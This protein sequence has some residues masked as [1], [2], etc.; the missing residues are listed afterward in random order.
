MLGGSA[1][2]RGM[3]SAALSAMS[4]PPAPRRRALVAAFVMLLM[5][6]AAATGRSAPV[7][8]SSDSAV[9]S[10]MP[11][12]I[13]GDALT[14]VNAERRRHGLLPLALDWR[15]NVAAQRH[16]V[17]MALRNK[18]THIGIDG[19][20]AGTRITL[21]LYRWSAWAENIAAGQTSARQVVTAWINSP[22]HRA[23]ILNPR[24]R[25]MGLGYRRALNGTWYWCMVL[26]APR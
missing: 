10:P 26:A 22:P 7:S 1:T 23:N 4:C 21:A 9:I 17:D 5:S 15:L 3:G 8:A 18:M 13:A 19:S 24:F 16:A 2:C 14:Y 12:T 20:N 11:N 25:H 6:G